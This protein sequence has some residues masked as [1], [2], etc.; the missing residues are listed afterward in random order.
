M[1]S[2]PGAP[3]TEEGDT[4]FLLISE[5]DLDGRYLPRAAGFYFRGRLYA[6][7]SLSRAG[8]VMSKPSVR[9]TVEIAFAMGGLAGNNFHGLGFLHAVLERSLT[10]DMISCTSGQID[11]VWKYLLAKNG[12]LRERYGVDDLESLGKVYMKRAEIR[13][14]LALPHVLDDVPQLALASL[15][16][17]TDVKS[18]C[19]SPFGYIMNVTVNSVPARLLAPKI[20]EGVLES[21]CDDF[22]NEQSVAIAFNSY[23]PQAGRETVHLN[24]CAQDLLNRRVPKKS[25]FRNTQGHA[26]FYAPI[27]AEGLLNALWIYEYGFAERTSIDGAYFRMVMLA[28]LSRV[29]SIVVV[30]PIQGRWMDQWPVTYGEREDLKTEVSFNSAY[31][32]ERLRIE[33]VNRLLKQRGLKR[34]FARREG[35]HHI[36]LYEF[37]PRTP[38]PFLAYFAEDSRVFREACEDARAFFETLPV[39]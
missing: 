5:Q 35:Y 24:P 8:P 13:P 2:Q 3:Y 27:N 7:E 20:A 30:R 37:E 26:T 31:L 16:H 18:M 34:K 17:I 25:S 12:R 10:P 33:L 36:D 28:E 29:R 4:H 11:I 22:N 38:Q 21:M 39:A 19:E 23:D 15:K 14:K 9:Q 6:R 32:G 1:R